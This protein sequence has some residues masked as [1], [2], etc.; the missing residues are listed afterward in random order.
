MGGSC[1]LYGFL[2]FLPILLRRSFGFSQSASFYLCTP[3]AA[4]A[5]VFSIAVSYFADK[6]QTRGVF[7]IAECLIG[8]A[9]LAIVGFV[10]AP[11]PRYFGTFLGMSGTTAL[12]STAL[13]WGQNNVRDDAKR[14]VVTVIQVV[15]AAIGGIY[16]SLV[17][18]QQVSLSPNPPLVVSQSARSY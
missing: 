10:E 5:V 14:S 6:H 3:P 7:V 16:S 4:V 11:G 8:I 17:F 15:W 18:R 2:F 1:G 9:G 12:I 13:S